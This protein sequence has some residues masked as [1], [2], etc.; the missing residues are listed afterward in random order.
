MLHCFEVKEEKEK[1]KKEVKNK[2]R[3]KILLQEVFSESDLNIKPSQE[4]RHTG[5]N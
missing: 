5:Q 2:I 4:R 1:E 3:K